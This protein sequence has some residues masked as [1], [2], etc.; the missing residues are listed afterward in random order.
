VTA[1]DYPADW[2]A[3]VLLRNGRPIHLRP[4]RPADGEA[5][6]VFH[7]ALSD[8]TVY[9]RFFSAKPE[10]T[11]RD[12]TYFTEVDH[13]TRVALV[14]LDR[15]AIVGVG[16]FDAL[17]DGQ[18]EVA[19]VIRDDIQGLGLGS[20]LLEHLTAAARER[21]VRRFVAEVLPEN[22]R[23]IATFREAGYEV[24]QRREDD[25][26]AVSFDIEPTAGSRAVMEAREHRAEARSVHRLLHPGRIAVVG[27]SRAPGGLG[28]ELLRHIVEGGYR[29]DLVAVH[30]E[31][32]E[33]LGVRCVRALGDVGGTIDLVVVVV[34]AQRV[35]AVIEDAARAGVHG[36]VVVSGGFGDV[37]GDGPAL[38]AALVAL[39]HRTGMRLVGPNALGLVNTADDIRLNASLVDE[40]P[41]AGR[42]GFFSQSGALG[43]S[44]LDRFRRRGLGLSTFVSAGNRAD[45][46]GNDLLQ[47]WEEDEATDLVMLHL[48]T[49]GNARKFA[50]IVHRLSAKK[51]VAMVRTGGAGQRHPLG[52]AVSSTMLSQ[53]AVDGILGDC[54]L[55]VVE[56][57]DQLIDV[58]RI[59]GSQPLPTSSH[60]AVIG[61]SDALAVMAVNACERTVLTVAGEPVTFARQESS[62]AYEAAIRAALDDPDVGCVLVI[63]VPPI[64]DRSDRDI[65]ETLR[66]CA[67]GGVTEPGAKPIIAVMV[68]ATGGQSPSDVPAFRDVEEALQALS[69]VARHAD[70]RR[71]PTAV[72]ADV[73]HLSDAGV[74]PVPRGSYSGAGASRLLESLGPVI[75]QGGRNPRLGCRVRLFEDPLYGPIIAV[76]VD[77]P[78]AEALD[79]RAYRLAPVSAEGAQRMLSELASLDVVL[80]EVADADR[81]L[82]DLSRCISD[83]SALSVHHPEVIEVDARR[84]VLPIVASGELTSEDISVTVSEPPLN[85][86]PNARRM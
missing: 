76:G 86:E 42:V 73:S 18:A 57:I 67:S 12:V 35:A 38:Q 47:Y 17:G 1:P 24:R 78:V 79:D 82:A 55:I 49:I 58:A 45:I 20:V 68:A 36:L 60:V 84:L 29:G 13:V 2:E 7:S 16:R 44:I 83:V 72:P 52:H 26:L 69:A 32:D 59:A 37:G 63:Y 39:V 70:W 30:P 80:R 77:D 23:M 21:G 65:R 19:F 40:M 33:I 54:G 10:L 28:H 46:S 22:H 3:D 85:R 43:G 61:N 34:P 62:A 5:L 56:G 64:E 53:R 25:V 31:V 8:R 4:I 6:R 50:R 71:G 9:F 27:A 81:Y 66:R 75:S 51:P 11:D 74:G 14:A 41:P 48:E 15:G